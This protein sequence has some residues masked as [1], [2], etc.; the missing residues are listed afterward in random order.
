MQFDSRVY[1][2]KESGLATALVE[3]GN[4]RNTGRATRLKE[5]RTGG[6]SKLGNLASVA[7][8][9]SRGKCLEQEEILHGGEGEEAPRS[10]HLIIISNEQQK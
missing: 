5:W 8:E 7:E 3:A 10:R 2:L 4:Q 1:N 9:V 6:R